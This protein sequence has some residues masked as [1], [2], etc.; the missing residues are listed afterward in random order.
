MVYGSERTV[1]FLPRAVSPPFRMDVVRIRFTWNE[2][3]ITSR[4]YSSPLIKTAIS[5][6]MGVVP[7]AEYIC[8][9]NDAK[10]LLVYSSR[11]LWV[12]VLSPTTVSCV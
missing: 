3:P 9:Y 5:C 7:T 11:V 10:T 12:E 6:L 8:G 4:P 2:V 1:R